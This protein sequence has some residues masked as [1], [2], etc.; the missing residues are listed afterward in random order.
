MICN[1]QWM[2]MV[3]QVSRAVKFWQS[4]LAGHNLWLLC[5][6]LT[7]YRVIHAVVKSH[8]ALLWFSQ[9]VYIY[10]FLNCK[11]MPTA[12]RSVGATVP[13]THLILDWNLT[14][15]DAS[16]G[17]SPRVRL[18]RSQARPKPISSPHA[19]QAGLGLEQAGFGGLRAWSPAQHI[20][21]CTYSLQMGITPENHLWFTPAKYH[22]FEHSSLYSICLCSW[23]SQYSQCW[24]FHHGTALSSTADDSSIP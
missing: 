20:T 4:I 9:R 15:I 5:W 24:S 8:L 2:F 7:H 22:G 10:I 3:T 17:L 13:N 23:D 19:G 6:T 21:T 11:Y 16:L 1:V 12:V 18:L 14:N